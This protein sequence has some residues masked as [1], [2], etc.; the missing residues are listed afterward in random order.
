[1]TT[2]DCMNC[3]LTLLSGDS[4]LAGLVQGMA[5][6]QRSPQA[7]AALYLA[8]RR[9]E[10][11]GVR[12]GGVAAALSARRLLAVALGEQICEPCGVPVQ[13][14]LCRGMPAAAR[15]GRLVLQHDDGRT[16]GSSAGPAGPA[17][18]PKWPTLRSLARAVTATPVVAASTPASLPILLKA[19]HE[20]HVGMSLQPAKHSGG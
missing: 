11:D 9:F 6:I 2:R 7:V 5:L 8:G 19:L 17:S 20:S 12:P 4:G 13:G 18:R 1:M 3:G 10:L 16:S 15:P 14:R